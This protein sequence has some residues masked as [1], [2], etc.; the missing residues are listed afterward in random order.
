MT[1]DVP[2]F[3]EFFDIKMVKYIKKY[4]IWENVK[5]AKVSWDMVF[6]QEKRGLAVKETIQS[7]PFVVDVSLFAGEAV[8]VEIGRKRH[9]ASNG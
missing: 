7:E 5:G 3:H 8:D 6:D 9:P 4:L 2:K 1:V